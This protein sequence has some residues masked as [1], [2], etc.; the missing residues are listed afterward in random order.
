M[1]GKDILAAIVYSSV[2]A[3]GVSGSAIAQG[4]AA[5]Q[6][7]ETMVQG[8][9]ATQDEAVAP[10]MGHGLV[11][12]AVRNSQGNELGEIGNI[13]ATQDGRIDAIILEAGGVLGLGAT[14][15]V[16]PWQRVQFA[17]GQEGGQ[18]YVIVDVPAD[19]LEAEFSR[20]EAT[21]SPANG[22][23]TGSGMGA[24]TTGGMDDGS[25]QSQQMQ[26]APASEPSNGSQPRQ[27]F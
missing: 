2:L 21:S 27:G 11:G 13:L 20:F 10:A 12:T 1:I 5:T 8:A 6:Q 7:G 14:K 16:V 15:F 25:S 3:L 18:A 23:D 17:S 4:S 19:Q 9:S 24:G 22:T 26:Q